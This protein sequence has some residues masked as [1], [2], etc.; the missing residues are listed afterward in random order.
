MTDFSRLSEF[1]HDLKKL[2]KDYRSLENDLTNFSDALRAKLPDTLPG[3]VRISNL[4]TDVIDPVF[5]VRK[6][7]CQSLKGRG[8]NSGLRLIYAYDPTTDSIMFIEIYFKG[9]QEIENRERILRYM[10]SLS[11]RIV[12]T[13]PEQSSLIQK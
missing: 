12:T 8:S 1:D 3:V 2:L 13:K 11:F 5:K 10:K 7:R 4:G 9:K 6:F